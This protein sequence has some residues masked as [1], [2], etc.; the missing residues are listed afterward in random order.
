MVVS[1]LKGFSWTLT[2]HDIDIDINYMLCMLFVLCEE[3]HRVCTVCVR[4]TI[5]NTFSYK[6][7][8]VNKFNGSY[9]IM[10]IYSS[11][12]TVR[13]ASYDYRVYPSSTDSI[14]NTSNERAPS[15][16]WR[17]GAPAVVAST[18]VTGCP[19]ESS[20]T[21]GDVD[22]TMAYSNIC[23]MLSSSS[24]CLLRLEPVVTSPFTVLA[25]SLF[26]CVCVCKCVQMTSN[27][28]CTLTLLCII[29]CD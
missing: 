2:L 28:T 21:K 6:N 12:Y 10:N 24:A 11:I 23:G 4:K 20:D 7:I 17:D 15:V 16:T 25:I 1:P 29:I 8:P 5:P 9:T 14:L 13:V 22:A 26:V 3:T 27:N 19:V 18:T